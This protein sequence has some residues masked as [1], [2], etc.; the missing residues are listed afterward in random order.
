MMWDIF[1]LCRVFLDNLERFQTC[2][3]LPGC[4]LNC[5]ISVF[6]VS[7]KQN[8]FSYLMQHFTSPFR[9]TTSKINLNHQSPVIPGYPLCYVYPHSSPSIHIL[10]STYLPVYWYTVYR[11]RR[12]S[13]VVFLLLV[14]HL[15]PSWVRRR[16]G[17]RDTG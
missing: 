15:Q 2:F 5:Y 11:I 16:W 8:Y 14:Q 12:R 17:V 3:I 4:S 10:F 13:V 1:R 7:H 6:E 9:S